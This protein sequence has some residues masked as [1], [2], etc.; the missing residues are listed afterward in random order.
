MSGAKRGS[1]KS[2]GKEKREE[3]GKNELIIYQEIKI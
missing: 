2:R 1:Q 3:R